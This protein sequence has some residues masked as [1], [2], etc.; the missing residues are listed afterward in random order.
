MIIQSPSSINRLRLGRRTSYKERITTTKATT[1]N[2]Q[3]NFCRE[4]EKGG[5][6][7]ERRGRERESQ[8]E[9]KAFGVRSGPGRV[10][11]GAEVVVDG[12]PGDPDVGRML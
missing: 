10:E 4:R 1:T 11:D 7:S 9:D 2:K 5:K 6:K 8:V 3:R 12:D